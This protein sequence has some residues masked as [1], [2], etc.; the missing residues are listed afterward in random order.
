MCLIFCNLDGADK[1]ESNSVESDMDR[2]SSTTKVLAV[3]CDAKLLDEVDFLLWEI[4]ILAY[5]WT[6]LEL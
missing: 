6:L 4:S 3:S 5:E 1:S 2:S